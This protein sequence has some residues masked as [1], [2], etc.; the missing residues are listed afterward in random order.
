MSFDS[1]AV[2]TRGSPRGKGNPCNPMGFAHAHPSGGAGSARLAVL[3][4]CA[5]CP[6][7]HS[8]VTLCVSLFV[9]LS[10]LISTK[11]KPLCMTAS[12]AFFIFFISLITSIS[13]IVS[14]CFEENGY[15]LTLIAT[16][17][18]SISRAKSLES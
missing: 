1:E 11:K 17:A 18:F 16:I 6:V 4:G 12:R 13:L 7:G 10:A 9:L 15:Y 5:L 3:K 2:K 8:P 14:I